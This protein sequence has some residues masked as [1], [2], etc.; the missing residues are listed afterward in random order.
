MFREIFKTE[1]LAVLWKAQKGVEKGH[2]DIHV[3]AELTVIPCG[4][5]WTVDHVLSFVILMQFFF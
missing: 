1:R 4:S 3:F 2:V 5:C